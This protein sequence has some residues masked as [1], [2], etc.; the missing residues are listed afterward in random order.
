MA[1]RSR[2]LCRPLAWTNARW[3]VGEIEQGI[4]GSR[5]HQAVVQQGQ[6]DLGHVQADEIRVKG[7]KMIVWM[8]LCAASAFVRF[9]LQ[10]S[11]V[12]SS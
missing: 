9:S 12:E 2:R 7:C 6:L 5:V 1:V 3:R 10:E 4:I 8:G 11:E